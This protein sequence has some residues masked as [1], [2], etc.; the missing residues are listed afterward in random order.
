MLRCLE[1]EIVCQ[2]GAQRMVIP[3]PPWQRWLNRRLGQGTR[4]GPLRRFIPKRS[5]EGLQSVDVLWHVLM[6]P[7]NYTLDFFSNWAINAKHRVVYLFDTLPIQMNLL[8]RLFS[9][10]EWSVRF[11]SFNDAIPLLAEQTGRSWQHADQAV[12]LKYFQPAPLAERV[13]GF[14]AYGRRHPKV[15]E[16]VSQF[17]V[18]KGLYYDYTTHG[19]SHPTAEPLQLLKQFAWHLC[20]SRFTFCWPVEIT[21]PDRAGSLSPITCRWFEAAAAGAVVL[22]QPPT[23]PHFREVFGD[24]CVTPIDPNASVEEIIAQLDQVWQNRNELSERAMAIRRR[25]GVEL[26]WSTRVR[27]ML[28]FLEQDDL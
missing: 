22:G 8:R 27:Q 6:G 16:A 3:Q 12:S 15:H 13:I 7:E 28:N 5:L 2:T 20:H 14:S 26:D 10:D 24:N 23:N 21:N 17:C 4:Y 9:G 11:T 1:D 18:A 19:R 25:M